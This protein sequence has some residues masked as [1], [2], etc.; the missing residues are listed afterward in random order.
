MP[1]VHYKDEMKDKDKFSEQM[2]NLKVPDIN[3]GEHPKMVKMAIM[4][5]ERSAVLGIWLVIVPCYFLLCVFMYY[6]FHVKWGL[7][8]AMF[9]LMSSL[10]KNPVMKFFS[11][12]VFVG[13]PIIGIVINTL[14][15]IHVQVQAVGP[16]KTKVKEFNITIKLKIRNIL[17]I[18]LS[19]AI[20]GVFLGYV[21][22]ENITIKN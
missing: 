5:A 7:F 10:D 6:Y 2:E 18:L 4:N 13:F 8:T 3:P 12:L 15:I 22:I 9:N 11:P 16:D 1:A 17:L 21:I 19:L 20:A 14:S